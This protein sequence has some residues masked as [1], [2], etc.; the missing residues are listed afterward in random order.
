MPISSHIESM[1]SKTSWIRKMFEEGVRRIKE[2]GAENVFDFSIGNPVFEPPAAVREALVKLAA[3]PTPGAHRYM[4]NP[5]Y[6][7]TRAFMAERLAGASGAPFTAAD[8]VMCVGAGGALN[9]VLRTLLDPG[10]EVLVIKPY[11][12]DYLNYIANYNGVPKP[13]D[14]NPDFSLNLEA[15]A[16][17]LTPRTKALIINSPHNPTGVVYSA[18][19]LAALG[20]LLLR[21]AEKTGNPVSL[22]ADE[23]YRYI[24]YD[25]EVPWVTASYPHS[26][27]VNSS[28]KDLA[29][30]GERIG[31]AAVSP[32]H[33]DR[34]G[35]QAG[36]VIA[37]RILGFVNAPAMMQRLLP[38]AGDARVDIAPYRKNRDLLWNHL[39]A[40]GFSCVKPQGAFYLFPK[41]P[42]A[43]DIAFVQQAQ[44]HNLLLVPGSGFGAPG[45]CRIAYCF[46][47]EMI[48]R[49]LPVFTKVAQACGMGK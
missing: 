29:L 47:T 20:E 39:T 41:T 23:P 24:S 34:A 10:D 49:S 9:I 40:L 13:V 43:D 22:I 3:D 36:L 28:S 16:A 33:A 37:L 45:Y 48:E 17:A 25:V 27:I 21:H 44:E 31:Y 12:V 38:L 46:E 14:S 11:F 4:P 5:G 6:P 2:Y 19:S 7:E 32:A 18:D 15:I 1:I 30:P 35:L 42:T 8:V 26:I